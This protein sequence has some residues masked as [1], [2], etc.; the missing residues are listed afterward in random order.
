MATDAHKEVLILR[1]ELEDALAKIEVWKALAHKHY[2]ER[3]AARSD[4]IALGQKLNQ[5]GYAA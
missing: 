3:N 1:A 2:E 4:A 5:M